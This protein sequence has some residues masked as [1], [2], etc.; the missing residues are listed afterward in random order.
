VVA[1]R[2]EER[3]AT[4]FAL[5]A[6]R[7]QEDADAFTALYATA[8]LFGAPIATRMS[9]R[10]TAAGPLGDALLFALCGT[11]PARAW[12]ARQ[13][14]EPVPPRAAKVPPVPEAP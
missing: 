9:R 12:T 11:R 1:R 4:G 14:R 5:G 6:A 3:P 10:W 13:D 2:L 8:D 7:A